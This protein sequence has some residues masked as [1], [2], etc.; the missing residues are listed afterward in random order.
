MSKQKS[1][2]DSN[3]FKPIP[4]SKNQ[5]KP[6]KTKKQIQKGKQDF[7]DELN[8]VNSHK[9]NAVQNWQ[10]LVLEKVKEEPYTLEDNL[11]FKKELKELDKELEQDLKDGILLQDDFSIEDS[12]LIIK[13]HQ[14]QV[15]LNIKNLA[16]TIIDTKWSQNI[17]P[18]NIELSFK[19]DSN[20]FYKYSSIVCISNYGVRFRVVLSDVLDKLNKIPFE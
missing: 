17:N 9:P 14:E 5:K 13:N 8:N 3:E 12:V 18:N 4:N 16:K 15:K 10:D 6:K 11:D 2:F 7:L 1:L 19:V 20:G